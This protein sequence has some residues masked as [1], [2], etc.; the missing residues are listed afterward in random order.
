M[1]IINFFGEHLDLSG[2]DERIFVVT[3]E[4]NAFPE[5]YRILKHFNPREVELSL[6][7]RGNPPTCEAM[8][9]F[10]IMQGFIK[11]RRVQ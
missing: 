1:S 7:Y 5:E 6:T 9:E 2:P 4:D 11:P 10:L 8:V 3:G